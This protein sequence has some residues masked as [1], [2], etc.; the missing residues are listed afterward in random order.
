[1]VSRFDRY[2]ATTSAIAAEFAAQS[3]DT[4]RVREIPNGVDTDR[5]RPATVAEREAI[6]RELGLP[7]GPLVTFVGIISPRKNV[8][9]ILRMFQAAV[10]EGAPGHLL[11]IGPIPGDDDP[12]YRSA[13]AFVTAHDLRVA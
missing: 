1:M 11:L 6:R 3:L 9:G 13:L 8:D 10:G 5:Y 2:I 4:S 7:E 12:F